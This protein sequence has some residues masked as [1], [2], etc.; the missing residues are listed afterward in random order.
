MNFLYR[1]FISVHLSPP[2]TTMAH[3]KD[4]HKTFTLTFGEVCEN[5]VRNEQI[6]HLAEK[7]FSLEELQHIRRYFDE[8]GCSTELLNLNE[9]LFEDDEEK[10]KAEPAYVLV[11]RDGLGTLLSPSEKKEFYEEQDQ[12][13][14]DKKVKMYGRVVNKHARHNLCFADEGHASDYENGM[15]TVVAF[16]DVPCLSKV[17]EMI[18]EITGKRLYAEGNYYYDTRKCGIGYHGDAERRLVVGIRVGEEMP[19]HYRW[20][21]NSRVVSKTLK[22]SLGD[23]DM[24]VMG[25]KAVGFD[26]KMRSKYTLRH[27]A[28][29][30][31][32]LDGKKDI[33][34]F[35][36]TLI[37]D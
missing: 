26:W 30:A 13:E 4:A 37:E 34:V 16:R 12:L 22:L 27:A 24:Y 28:G 1:K 18:H 9:L 33:T 21:K 17:R 36:E 14:K 19:L 23:G 10:D 7:G 29:A 15:G 25:E 5:H 6:G 8:R 2:L 11:L 31:K 20:Y 32:F 35:E 3:H